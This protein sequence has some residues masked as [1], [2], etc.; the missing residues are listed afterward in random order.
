MSVVARSTVHAAAQKPDLRWP[1]H[2][3]HLVFLGTPHHGAPLERAVLG[4]PVYF[5]DGDPERDAQAQQTLEA[6]RATWASTS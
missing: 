4:R 1:G 2:L 5:V 6:Q 3:K